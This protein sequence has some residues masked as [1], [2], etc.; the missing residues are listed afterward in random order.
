MARNIAG[1][2][3][4]GWLCLV[5]ACGDPVPPAAQAGVSI[6]IQEYDTKDPAHSGDRCP[7]S[8]HWVNV[9]YERGKQPTSQTQRTSATDHGPT[10]VNNQDG[11]KVT[12]SVKPKGSGF[13]VSAEAYGHAEIDDL[14]NARK[15]ISPSIIRFTIPQIGQGD[16]DAP[17]VISLQDHASLVRYETTQCQFSTEGG[18]R[19]V[20]AG[21]IWASVRCEMLAD[22]KSPGANCQ[23]DTGF[24]VFENC[25]Q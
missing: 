22:I 7:P 1:I 16:T 14:N 9:P 11:D 21:K 15:E 18:S 2:G 3:V 8:R 20:A 6:H 5:A 19:E 17:G 23:V 12:C 13:S 4:L 10:A 24:L 25:A